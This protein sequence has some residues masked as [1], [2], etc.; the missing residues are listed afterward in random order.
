MGKS[1]ETFNKKEREKKKRK[2][3][4]EKAERRAERKEQKKLEALEGKPKED[5]F[6]YVDEDGN[7]TS[8]PPDPKKK[9][10]INAEDIVLGIPKKGEIDPADL[11]RKGVVKFFKEDKGYGFIVDPNTNESF[12]VHAKSL[13]EPITDRDKV[14]FEVEMGPKGAN[15]VNVNLV[16]K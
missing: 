7:L 16:K 9:R 15:A 4:K 8:T 12:F 5:N 6:M 3:K 2:K 13:S 11:I 14:T 10:K 1:Q